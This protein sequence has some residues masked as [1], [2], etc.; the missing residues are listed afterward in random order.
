MDDLP[1]SFVIRESSHPIHNP[2]TSEKLAT[3]G[4]ALQLSPG[5][6]MLDLA[7]GSGEM[8]CTWARDHGLTGTGVDIS[9]AFIG[10]ARARAAE[11][12]V[13][14]QVTF[15]H[16]DA[17]GYVA[18]QPAGIASCLGATWI[19]GGVAGTVDLLRQS[20]GPGGIM[21]IGEPNWRRDPPDQTTVE[22]CY[23]IGMEGWLPLPELIES[24]GLLGCDVVEMVLADQDSWDRYAAAQW[25]SIRRWLDA[26]PRDELAAEMRAELASSPARHVR[27]RREYLGWG[28]FALM[29]R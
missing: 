24:L 20:L 15:I 7:C 10:A 25:L 4:H 21:L 23:G 6:T 2:F 14:N 13:A 8:L 11:L 29:N 1:R 26:N 18:G 5:T 22:G 9:S 27:Y 19:G 3:L 17:A 28:V 16:G 12:D